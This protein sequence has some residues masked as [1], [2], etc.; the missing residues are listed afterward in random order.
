MGDGSANFGLF[1]DTRVAADGPAGT[2]RCGRAA[3]PG[4]Q[5]AGAF[6]MY[7]APAWRLL[8]KD[9]F[10]VSNPGFGHCTSAATTC[11]WRKV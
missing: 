4:S 5:N 1:A 10:F 6:D 8:D 2:E 11:A 3:I 9:E 7:P